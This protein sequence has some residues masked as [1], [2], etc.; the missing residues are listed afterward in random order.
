V[1]FKKKKAPSLEGEGEL[2]SQSGGRTLEP[3]FPRCHPVRG[4]VA[5]VLPSLRGQERWGSSHGQKEKKTAK[6]S[7]KREVSGHDN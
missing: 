4:G 5:G 6:R 2:A 3:I 7:K 1:F